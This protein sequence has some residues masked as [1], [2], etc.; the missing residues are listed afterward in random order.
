MTDRDLNDGRDEHGHPVETAENGDTRVAG[1]PAGEG[2]Y[3]ENRYEEER[4]YD[5]DGDDAGRDRTGTGEF[6]RTEAEAGTGERAGETS[7]DEVSADER[8]D[9]RTGEDRNDDDR[10]DDR[11][12]EYADET[13]ADAP[14]EA[15]AET[16]TE[17]AAGIPSDPAGE[18]PIE[19]ILDPAEAD[20]FKD[21]WHDL[22]SAFVD[23]P[24]DAVQRAGDLTDEVVDA[25]TQALA[26]HKATLDDSWTGGDS[27]S[28]TEKL[29][30]ALRG[31]RQFLD[32][33]LAS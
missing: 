24:G 19:R 29:R 21:R 13:S 3:E 18:S 1:G 17:T 27:P 28:D 11:T 8:A 31:Y 6:G 14:A 2:G 16:S 15:S 23:D 5:E 12:D 9:E 33:I 10:T 4:R 30:L 20:R 25:L 22:Q 26:K 32:R 7:T